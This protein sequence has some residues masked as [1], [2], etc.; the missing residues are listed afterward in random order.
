MIFER[1][2]IGEEQGKAHRHG[3]RSSEGRG[4]PALAISPGFTGRSVAA[5]TL[6]SAG[7]SASPEAFT[8]PTTPRSAATAPTPSWAGG[9][10]VRGGLELQETPE[11]QRQRGTGSATIIVD[12][13]VPGTALPQSQHLLYFPQIPARI[14]KPCCSGDLAVARFNVRSPPATRSVL[15]EVAAVRGMVQA[16]FSILLL[17]L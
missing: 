12:S 6:L 2:R 1:D 10:R 15:I 16:D 5:D 17:T 4:P 13:R 14:P 3:S 8:R 9:H 11:L 7:T